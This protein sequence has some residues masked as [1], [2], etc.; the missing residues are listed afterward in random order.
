L[1][2]HLSPQVV[3]SYEKLENTLC[4]EM[5][6]VAAWVINRVAKPP[7]GAIFKGWAAKAMRR[8]PNLDITTCHNYEIDYKYKWRCVTTWCG[9]V[10]GRHSKSIDVKKHRC[11]ACQGELELMPQLKADGTPRKKREPNGFSLYVK[12]HFARTKQ[13]HPDLKHGDVMKK[14]GEAFKAVDL[15]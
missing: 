8:Y 11:G 3:D 7:H 10:F 9:R 5:C 15:T 13:D 2:N 14:L 12:R 6:H 1:T 4:H